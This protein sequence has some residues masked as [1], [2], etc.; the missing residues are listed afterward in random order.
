MLVHDK[1]PG[2][3]EPKIIFMGVHSAR[4]P[5]ILADTGK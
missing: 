4:F 1:Q 5:Q 3:V 2:A